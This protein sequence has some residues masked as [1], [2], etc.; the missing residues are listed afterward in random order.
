MELFS[1]SSFKGSLSIC[2]GLILSLSVYRHICMWTELNQGTIIT[3]EYQFLQAKSVNMC[4]SDSFSFSMW[5]LSPVNRFKSRK[6]GTL[7]NH[8][9]QGKS[10]NMWWCVSL[11]FSV[12]IPLPVNRIK[13]RKQLELLSNL[14]HQAVSI[15]MWWSNYFFFSVWVHLPVNR[16]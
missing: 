7:E 10:V 5:M 15:N 16:I 8:I 3:V 9:L 4:W 1:G 6:N 13:W 12:W 14:I 2:G 11:Y